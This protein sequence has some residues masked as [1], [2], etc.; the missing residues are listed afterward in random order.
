MPASRFAV[1]IVSPLT[2]FCAPHPQLIP[3]PSAGEGQGEGAFQQ[4][5]DARPQKLYPL[6]QFLSLQG[7]GD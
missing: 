6:T 4:F 3:S 7:R 1:R 2:I 5:G